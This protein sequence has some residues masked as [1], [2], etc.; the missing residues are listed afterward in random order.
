MWDNL[1]EEL[2]W[3]K[4]N[5]PPILKIREPDEEDTYIEQPKLINNLF[6]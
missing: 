3:G 2:I 5:I 6:E 1:I 4:D